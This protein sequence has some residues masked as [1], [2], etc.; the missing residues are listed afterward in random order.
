MNKSFRK[1][2]IPKLKFRFGS[3]PD[4]LCR[5]AGDSQLRV[6]HIQAAR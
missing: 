5:G 1:K 4:G 3:D 2:N 6:Q